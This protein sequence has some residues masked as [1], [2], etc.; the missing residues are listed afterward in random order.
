MSDKQALA[1]MASRIASHS[2]PKINLRNLAACVLDRFGEY[3]GLAGHLFAAFNANPIGSANAVRILAD[4]VKLLTVSQEDS[5]DSDVDLADL[6]AQL[7][8]VL[9][10]MAIEDAE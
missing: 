10:G 9:K 5:D 7:K 4:V 8:D 6:E 1:R 2:A 3:D